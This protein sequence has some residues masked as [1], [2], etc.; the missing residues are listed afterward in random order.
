MRFKKNLSLVCVIL[1]AVSLVMVSHIAVAADGGLN[2]PST[3]VRIEVSDDTESY[4]V[5]VL[6]DV[7]AGYDV[8]NG[9]YAGWCV[10]RTADMLRS[11]AV[12]TVRLYSSIEPP[13]TLAAEKWD[14]VNYVLNHKQGSAE[15]IQQAIWYFINLVGNYT[16]T[17]GVAWAII[18]DAI[19]N[20]N[21]FIPGYGQ[22]IAV[23]CFPVVIL[24]QPTDVQINII[25]ISNPVIPEFPSLMIP[26]IFA[27]AT[28]MTVIAYKGRHLWV[29]AAQRKTDLR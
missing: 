21:G 3:L 4:F 8:E 13:G 27:I 10:D 1:V 26:V 18:N 23:I 19:A 12:H 6:S 16:P 22:T 7:P 9:T 28:L 14:M 20:G 2:L 24:P 5:T 29:R 17:S 11:P 15:D 25:E